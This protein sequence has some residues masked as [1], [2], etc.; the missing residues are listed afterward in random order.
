M[1]QVLKE[2]LASAWRLRITSLT[3]VIEYD[4]CLGNCVAGSKNSFF[5]GDQT[6]VESYSIISKQFVLN[7]VNTVVNLSLDIYFFNF[8]ESFHAY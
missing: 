7:C 1:L 3:N 4:L 5:T 8:Y 6:N 2:L